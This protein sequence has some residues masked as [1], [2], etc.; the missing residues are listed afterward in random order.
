MHTTYYRTAPNFRGAKFSRFS[1]VALNPKIKLRKILDYR[2]L[3]PTVRNPWC[4]KIVSAKF[5]KTAIR[6]NC[7]PRKSDAIRYS[8]D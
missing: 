5:L 4:A 1:R 8:I 3:M 6:E 7:A 2:I